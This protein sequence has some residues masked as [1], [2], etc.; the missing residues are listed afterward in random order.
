MNISLGNSKKKQTKASIGYGLYSRG[1]Q[2]EAA[3]KKSSVFDADD[4]DD[5]SDGPG[6][7]EDI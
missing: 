2:E 5:D 6:K 1:A 7:D 3:K 4:D